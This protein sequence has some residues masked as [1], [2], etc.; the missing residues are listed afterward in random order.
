MIK[1]CA[2]RRYICAHFLLN[3]HLSLYENIRAVREHLLLHFVVGEMVV[4]KRSRLYGVV[5][6][7]RNH[8]YRLD[9]YLGEE[10]LATTALS[11]ELEHKSMIDEESI[12][13]YID[14]ITKVSPTGRMFKNG[15]FEDGAFAEFHR[16]A[17]I[18]FSRIVAFSGQSLERYYRNRTA[19]HKPRKK[20]CQNTGTLLKHL[21]CHKVAMADIQYPL[22][23]AEIF[24]FFSNFEDALS[25][26]IHFQEFILILEKSGYYSDAAFEMHKFLLQ[27]VR[28][29]CKRLSVCEQKK[30]FCS[31]AEIC[32]GSGHGSSAS[33]RPD[34]RDWK[35]RRITAKSWKSVLRTLF[36][37]VSNRLGVT[38]VVCLAPFFH[39][40][41]QRVEY[42]LKVLKFL[43]ECVYTARSFRK[44]VRARIKACKGNSIPVDNSG[45]VD[46]ASQRLKYLTRKC[47]ISYVD[48]TNFIF[49]GQDIFYVNGGGIFR[50]EA[51]HM[52]EF[53]RSASKEG[54]GMRSL[55]RTMRAYLAAHKIRLVD[56]LDARS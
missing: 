36:S 45:F 34:R 51:C 1:D 9:V 30:L 49:L 38:D 56:I 47:D 23:V 35:N 31:V 26:R 33:F 39:K 53:L 25:S 17:K 52:A 16:D 5:T 18:P 4:L 22:L 24:A 28:K 48:G 29:E 13:E 43:M 55:R 42:R 3:G 32:I 20:R 54:E 15:I 14:S 44:L 21:R 41:E 6:A 37:N 7:A 10:A 40:C 46:S 8:W 2:I 27:F 11:D 19:V 12:I 50:M